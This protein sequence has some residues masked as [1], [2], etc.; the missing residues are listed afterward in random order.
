MD[1]AGMVRMF[2][3]L[4]KSG[5]RGFLRVS[6]SVFEEALNQFIANTSVIARM[7]VSML[8]NRKM[9]I[10]K[11]VI[12][13]TFHLP[14]EG[15]VSFSELP[16]KEVADMKAL[17]STTEVPFMPSSKKKDM[18]VEYRLLHDIEAK[19]LSAKAGSLM[20]CNA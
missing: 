7:V 20:W 14:T 12:L 11:D 15:I 9:V 17:F 16:A 19:S 10:T 1:D 8:V 13:E 3:S 18:K 6:G 2:K 4:E 5:L